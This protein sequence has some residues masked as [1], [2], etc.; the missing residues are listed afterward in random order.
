MSRI[1]SE[2]E[3]TRQRHRGDDL[4]ALAGGGRAANVQVSPPEDGAVSSCWD[5]GLTTILCPL[6]QS[7]LCH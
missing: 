3:W 4:N 1:E 5:H 2:G 7:T 6:G